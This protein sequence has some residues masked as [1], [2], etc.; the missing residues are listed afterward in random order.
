MQKAMLNGQNSEKKAR[1]NEVHK[2]VHAY[3]LYIDKHILSYLTVDLNQ[4]HRLF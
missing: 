1:C 3:V 2:D 4:I